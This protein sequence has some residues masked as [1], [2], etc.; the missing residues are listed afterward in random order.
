MTRTEYLFG[1]T[2]DTYVG[3][4]FPEIAYLRIKHAEKLLSQLNSQLIVDET[5]PTEN[6]LQIR[7]RLLAIDDAI[8]LWRK[9]VEDY[10]D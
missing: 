8:K 2:K 1:H 9:I 7:T 4:N 10:E 3:I 6:Q 5:A